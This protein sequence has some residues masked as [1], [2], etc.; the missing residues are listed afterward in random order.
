VLKYKQLR[1]RE[2]ERERVLVRLFSLGLWGQLVPHGVILV[3][4]EGTHTFMLL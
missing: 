2:R 3:I 1:E 4:S